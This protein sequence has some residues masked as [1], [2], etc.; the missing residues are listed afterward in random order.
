[1]QGGAGQCMSEL[2]CIVERV[3]LRHQRQQP[4]DILL[5][6]FL[7]WPQK[8]FRHSGALGCRTMTIGMNQ[9]ETPLTFQQIPVQFLPVA[10]VGCKVQQIVLNL[11]SGS[12]K[13]AKPDERLEVDRPATP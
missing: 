11:K 10:M 1:M 5:A 7:A 4:A 12:E 6:A 13:K 3:V 8:Q 9:Q 2:T